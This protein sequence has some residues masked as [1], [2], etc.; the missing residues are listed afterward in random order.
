VITN[1]LPVIEL[2]ENA[3]AIE[4]I[5]LGGA[6]QPLARCFA[7]PAT[8]RAARA[9]S[10]D[11]SLICVRGLTGD[12]GLSDIDALE[13]EVKHAMIECARESVLM[14]TA[15]TL[16]GRGI[17][18]HASLRDVTHVLATGICR[19]ELQWLKSHAANVRVICA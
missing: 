11:K 12:G 7:G 19:A 18:V 14:V 9:L 1:S 5:D 3:P 6:Y 10:V 4:L 17:H 8:V 13:A 2:T 15:R 16:S